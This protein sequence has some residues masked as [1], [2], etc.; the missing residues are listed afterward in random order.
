MQIY[1]PW[2]VYDLSQH[3]HGVIITHVFKVDVVHLKLRD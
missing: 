1:S 3:P 2:L